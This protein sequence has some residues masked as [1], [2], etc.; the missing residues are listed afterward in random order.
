MGRPRISRKAKTN[1]I[2]KV[3]DR[4]R[5]KK[6]LELMSAMTLKPDNGK[7]TLLKPAR[8][9]LLIKHRQSLQA[10]DQSDT[11]EDYNEQGFD[12]PPSSPYEIPP[13][14]K[15]YEKY[16]LFRDISDVV[17][18]M[19]QIPFSANAMLKAS[20]SS[21]NNEMYITRGIGSLTFV[22][23]VSTSP[24]SQFERLPIGQRKIRLPIGRY[25]LMIDDQDKINDMIDFINRDIMINYR[26]HIGGNVYVSVSS[27]YPC[28]DIRYF[29]SD[30]DGLCPTLQGIALRFHEWHD[31]L[32]A[33]RHV[34]IGAPFIKNVRHCS[35]FHAIRQQRL[36]CLECSPYFL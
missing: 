34:L 33:H 7:L 16:L 1:R 31:L 30:S 13:L 27:S 19:F 3:N 8:E 36:S 12:I 2:S 11:L 17:D 28:I 23:D 20:F 35:E 21:V 26:H 6:L 5:D 4:N 29:T 32:K 15:G 10:D 24:T 18:C 25:N 22:R 14:P 9:A